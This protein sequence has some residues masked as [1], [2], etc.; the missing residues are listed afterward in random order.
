MAN[1]QTTQFGG[2]SGQLIASGI[3]TDMPL[4]ALE[5]GVDATVFA[6]LNAIQGMMP[7]IKD[8]FVRETRVFSNPL[9]RYI[10]KFDERYGAGLEQVAVKYGAYNEKQDGT[11]IPQG[12]P[13]MTSQLDLVNFAYSVDIGIPDYLVDKAVLDEGQRGSVFAALMQAPLKTIAA[14]RYRAWVQLISDVID[15]T[16]SISSKDSFNGVAAAGSAA[17]VT[18]NPTITGYAGLVEKND[19]VLPPVQ[20]GELYTFPDAK[21]A[22]DVANRIKSVAADFKFESTAF[23]KLGIS[24]FVTSDP[25]LIAETK[26]LDA[27]DNV[28]A[29]ANVNGNGSNF[30]YAGFPTVSAREYI[31][32]FVGDIVEIDSFGS[33]PTDPADAVITYAGYDLKFVLI[34]RDAFV[35]IIKNQSVEGQRCAKKRMTGYN[36]QGQMVFSVWRGVDSYAMVARAA[37]NVAFTSGNFTVKAGTE[38]VTT[39]D[40]IAPGTV[41]TIAAATGYDLSAVTVNGTSLTIADDKATFAMP[42]GDAAISVTTVSE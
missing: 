29:E 15:G 19:A 3:A 26:V 1:P 24:T 40:A 37:G 5:Q 34:D 9:E 12:I 4:V 21:A 16:R 18:Y 17:S 32:Q 20:V 11:C 30:G 41:L 2:F 8:I 36:W 39:G 22:L 27:M 23:N 10:T 33:L 28:F 31:R 42:Q 6:N 25:I 14:A 7:K 13:E 35:E 38:S